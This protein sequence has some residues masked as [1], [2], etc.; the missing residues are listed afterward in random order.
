MYSETASA[1]H[2]FGPDS[3]VVIW[4][5]FCSTSGLSRPQT[6]FYAA[7]S[8]EVVL[9][10]ESQRSI[11]FSLNLC[12]RN[13]LYVILFFRSA[14]LWFFLLLLLS[15]PHKKKYANCEVFLV[16][17]A[18]I[19][20][21]I[22]S[23]FLS[24]S[25]ESFRLKYLMIFLSVIVESGKCAAEKSSNIRVKI[26]GIWRIFLNFYYKFHFHNRFWNEKKFIVHCCYVALWL[27]LLNSKMATRQDQ[28]LW[29]Y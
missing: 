6:R 23:F 3:Y 28:C 8:S 17:K 29:F 25:G 22:G 20:F 5:P 24:F 1:S 12:G 18:A 27:L 14:Y 9:N 4:R 10:L 16:P 13:Y 2:F 19:Y 21:K 7:S 26:W 11:H 15:P